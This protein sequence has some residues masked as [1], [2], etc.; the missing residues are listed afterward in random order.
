[1][2]SEK[3]NPFEPLVAMIADAVV[4]RLRRAEEPRLLTIGEAAQQLRRSERWMRMEIAAGRLECVREGRGRPRIAREA[5]DRWIA[6]H[7]G[8]E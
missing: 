5:L 4:E 1:M 3:P 8:R 6:Q 7:N 2:K